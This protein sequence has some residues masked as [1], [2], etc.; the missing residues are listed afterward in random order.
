[1]AAPVQIHFGP[2]RIV[3]DANL[4][5]GRE[6]T[7]PLGYL[8]VRSKRPFRSSSADRTPAASRLAHQLPGPRHTPAFFNP[9]HFQLV[10]RVS[11]TGLVL[12]CSVSM[13]CVRLFKLR[14]VSVQ[15]ISF[16]LTSL[17]SALSAAA[18]PLPMGVPDLCAVSPG[19]TYIAAG[20]TA[21]YSGAGRRRARRARHARPRLEHH[22]DRRDAPRLSRWQAARGHH[23]SPRVNVQ[24]VITD[25]PINTTVDP[26]QYGH[27]LVAF[28]EVTMIGQPRTP[29]FSRWPRNWPPAPGP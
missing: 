5:T 11:S 25:S 6:L 13:V 8:R 2:S 27:G 10:S 17:L 18:Q 23:G 9:G 20:Q 28:G 3:A 19:S 29:T 7:D 21:T 14:R 4:C 12:R 24:I 1:M 15:L 26:E 16:I 22:A